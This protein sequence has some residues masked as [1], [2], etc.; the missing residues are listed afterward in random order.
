MPRRLSKPRSTWGWP[1]KPWKLACWS[2]TPTTTLLEMST[3]ELP[4]HSRLD[5]DIFNIISSFCIKVPG[6]ILANTGVDKMYSVNSDL[7]LLQVVISSLS[8][9]CHLAK[10]T[11]VLTPLQFIKKIRHILPLLSKLTF[12]PP[13]I[14]L[15]EKLIPAVFDYILPHNKMYSNTFWLSTFYHAAKCTQILSEWVN[16]KEV[17][18]LIATVLKSCGKMY[19]NTFGMSQFWGGKKSLFWQ[20]LSTFCHAAKCT[21]IWSE[22][23]NAKEVKS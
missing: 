7:L 9:L 14:N 12:L 6:W 16:A 22:L 21:Q 5:F 18:K 3:L 10:C 11:W 17:K 23:A 2:G 19:S 15:R 4:P 8:T 1:P 20:Y 13:W